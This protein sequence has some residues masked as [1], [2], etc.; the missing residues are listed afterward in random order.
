MHYLRSYRDTAIIRYGLFVKGFD[1]PICYASLCCVDRDDKVI[2]LKKAIDNS[3]VNN[4]Q[5]IELSRLYGCGTLPQ[6]TISFFLGYIAKQL[7]KKGYKYMIT[8]V[9][10]ALGFTGGSVLAS[11]FIPYALRPVQ[12][13]Y[14]NNCY[15]TRRNSTKESRSN[16]TPMPPNVLYVKEL[17]KRRGN[18]LNFSR[19]VDISKGFMFFETTIEHEI[20]EIR[21]ELESVWSDKS[22]Y[23]GTV[24][25]KQGDFRKSKGQCGV[26][27]LL[28]A[29]RLEKQGYNILFCEGNLLDSN[30]LF[31]I[32]NHCWIKII[33]YNKRKQNIIIDITADQN[34]YPKKIIFAA[35]EDLNISR[36]RYEAVSEI[37]P[38]SV[39]V[40]HLLE[41]LEYIENELIEKD[42]K[43][44]KKQK[45]R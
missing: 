7:G 27:S 45:E 29:R 9:N 31:S 37:E 42:S 39:D 20:Y 26:S 13:Y 30:D 22:R 19:P 25:S 2:A 34:G 43:F 23:H 24:I 12:Y 32:H 35:E 3:E 14:S 5:I 40:Q 38:K 8:A 17:G 11:G 21:A 41:R 1:Y 44:S 33:G 4:N 36:I 15:C 18:I 16:K 6:N 28:L 10:I